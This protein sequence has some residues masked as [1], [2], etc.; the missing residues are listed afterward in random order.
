M[1]HAWDRR[2][3]HVPFESEQIEMNATPGKPRHRWEHNIKIDINKVGYS[4]VICI[5]LTTNMNHC[6]FLVSMAINIV[7]MR[8]WNVNSLAL[9]KEGLCYLQLHKPP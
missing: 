7:S 5:L 4:S 2:E 8:K 9:C 6:L 3:V 1:K